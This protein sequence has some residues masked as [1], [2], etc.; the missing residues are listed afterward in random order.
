MDKGLIALGFILTAVLLAAIITA[1][2]GLEG[3]GNLATVGA[4]LAAS[5]GALQAGRAAKEA[6]R[7]NVIALDNALRQS[8]PRVTITSAKIEGVAVVNGTIDGWVS[9]SLHN[10]GA[11]DAFRVTVTARWRRGGELQDE[12][13]RL[14]DFI[15]A[16]RSLPDGFEVVRSKLDGRASA[17]YHEAEVAENAVMGRATLHLCVFYSSLEAPEAKWHTALAASVSFDRAVRPNEPIS[18]PA[19][20]LHV[21]RTVAENAV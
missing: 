18:Q 7:A 2:L 4:L 5:W 15:E 9:A 20:V 21:H 11:Q 19:P 8:R 1:G 14:N 17:F 12:A 3:V 6:A 13:M 10:S 16:S